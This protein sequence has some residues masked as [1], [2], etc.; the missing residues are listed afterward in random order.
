MRI[1]PQFSVDSSLQVGRYCPAMENRRYLLVIPGWFLIASGVIC[2]LISGFFAIRTRNFLRTASRAEGIVIRLVEKRG[3]SADS[4]NTFSPVYI[5]RDG[6][7]YGHEILSSASSY[8]PLYAVG[9]K[10]GVYYQARHPEEARIDGFFELWGTSTIAGGVGTVD[11]VVGMVLLC[12]PVIWG[13][14]RRKPSVVEAV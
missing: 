6:G 8:P 4:G 1:I 14:F 9:E 12:W 3:E 10:I 2:L 11:L 7:G 13:K 5:F